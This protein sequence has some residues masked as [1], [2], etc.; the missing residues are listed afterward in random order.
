MKDFSEQIVRFLDRDLKLRQFD[1]FTLL[2]EHGQSFINNVVAEEYDEVASSDP[3]VEWISW[4]IPDEEMRFK[5]PRP[6][7]NHFM[8]GI[9]SNNQATALHVTVAPDSKRLSLKDLS[10]LTHLPDIEQAIVNY[11]TSQTSDIATCMS[12]FKSVD[13][14]H[15]FRVQLR[16]NFRSSVIMPSQVVQ[17]HPPSDLFPYGNCNVML[18]DSSG[19]YQ[20]CTYSSLVSIH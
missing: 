3:A 13:I 5:A 14:W 17:A 20:N 12:Y 11:V 4:V 18:L 15:K 1:L 6:V 9:L 8:N 16:S 10:Q 19:Q 7:R 2:A